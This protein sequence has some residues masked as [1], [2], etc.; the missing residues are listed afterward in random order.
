M[1]SDFN[2]GDSGVQLQ[3]Q[4]NIPI[5]SNATNILFTF[6]GV[7]TGTRVQVTATSQAGG[8]YA[9]Y[10]LLGTEF[11]VVDT[12]LWE[13]LYNASGNSLSSTAPMPL[14]VVGARL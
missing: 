6:K 3:F 8:A 9:A 13:L 7:T 11:S 12:Y 10:T 5:P 1:G 2:V 14:I 4:P